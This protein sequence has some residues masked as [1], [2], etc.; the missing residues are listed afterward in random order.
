[1]PRSS[2]A[3]T[4]P[5]VTR[6][7]SS[8]T[9]LQAALDLANDN[10]T[11]SPP[12]SQT[13]ANSHASTSTITA[14]G[15]SS[16]TSAAPVAPSKHGLGYTLTEDLLICRASIAASED[17]IV[18]ISQRGKQFQCKMH[19]L[20]IQFLK[21]QYKLDQIKYQGTSSSAKEL[22]GKPKIYP[23]QTPQGVFDRFKGTIGHR[24][25]KFLSV[26]ET[27]DIGKGTDEES[28]YQHYKK[29][30][31]HRYPNFGNLD[32]LRPCIEYLQEK[33][34]F[35]SWRVEMNKFEKGDKKPRPIGKKA[36]QQEQADQKLVAEAISTAK[37]ET[38]RG[39]T[40]PTSGRD[41]LY[42]KIIPVLDNVASAFLLRMEED[43]EALLMEN[44]S[45]PLKREW[46]EEKLRKKL[47]KSRLKRRKLEKELQAHGENVDITANTYVV[48]GPPI[49]SMEGRS[50]P[51]DEHVPHDA[52]HT[53]DLGH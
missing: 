1:M 30:Y 42:N 13:N 15:V 36:A 2:T 21:E 4:T 53:Q 20:Y 31:S 44:V 52:P 48:N 17:S 35:L 29:T 47:L 26:K 23:T 18:S 38:N 10:G 12:N 43:N 45:S 32:D 8:N 40:D 9:K 34:K 50:P 39:S 24:V 46:A 27:T 28:M 25:S 7:G 19:A 37:N 6:R 33:P 51:A 11:T 3:A 14:T 22:Y 41:G 16:V 49:S 5:A